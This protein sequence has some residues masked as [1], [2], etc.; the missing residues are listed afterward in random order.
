M[1]TNACLKQIIAFPKIVQYTAVS[2]VIKV[3]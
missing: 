3:K 2:N 1:K